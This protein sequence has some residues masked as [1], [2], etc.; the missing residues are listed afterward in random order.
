MPATVQMTITHFLRSRALT[1][2]I[3]SI[4]EAFL[5][6]SGIK[7]ESTNRCYKRQMYQNQKE[8]SEAF[9]AQFKA[10]YKNKTGSTLQ[11]F[12]QQRMYGDFK[13]KGFIC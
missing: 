5:L 9:P 4:E 2:N 1:K 3:K 12:L 8:H 6:V 7:Y 13:R 11:L 10:G